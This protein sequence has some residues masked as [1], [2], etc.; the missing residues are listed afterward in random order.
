MGEWL[1][2]AP[3]HYL[4]AGPLQLAKEQCAFQAHAA[5]GQV[6]ARLPAQQFQLQRNGIGTHNQELITTRPEADEHGQIVHGEGADQYELRAGREKAGGQ[7]FEP[8]KDLAIARP[9]AGQG[10]QDTLALD[11]AV[12]GKGPIEPPALDA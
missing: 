7:V 4:D 2:H 3:V 10:A 1:V 8:L 12:A 9:G 6:H 11:L 5:R